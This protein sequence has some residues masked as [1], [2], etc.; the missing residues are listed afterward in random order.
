MTFC[1]LEP[2]SGLERAFFDFAEISEQ[3][4]MKKSDICSF[5]CK[6]LSQNFKPN[7][8]VFAKLIEMNNLD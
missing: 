1:F 2:K 4:W 3:I 6:N 5:Y 8:V 7:I